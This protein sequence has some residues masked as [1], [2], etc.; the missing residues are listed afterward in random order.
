MVHI[1]EGTL[2][3]PLRLKMVK[4]IVENNEGLIQHAMFKKNSRFLKL[5]AVSLPSF[6]DV[7][8][9]PEITKKYF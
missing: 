8:V 3:H 2:D 7:R 5:I 4:R 1:D 6:C 9:A